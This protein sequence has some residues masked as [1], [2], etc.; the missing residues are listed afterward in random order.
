MKAVEEEAEPEKKPI[1]KE[2]SAKE[3]E[4]VDRLT[5]NEPAEEKKEEEEKE[6]KKTVSKEELETILN[7]LTQMQERQKSSTA[8]ISQTETKQVSAEDME[9]ILTRLTTYDSTKWPPE[10]KP[11]IFKVHARNS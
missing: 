1:S 2:L 6:E 8:P 4:I 7:R 9:T 3:K 5:K 11:E 10:S